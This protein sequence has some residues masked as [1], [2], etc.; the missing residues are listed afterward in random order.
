M[1]IIVSLTYNVFSVLLVVHPN[2]IE[3]LLSVQYRLLETTIM[4]FVKLES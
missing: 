2:D 1:E 4:C 3:I